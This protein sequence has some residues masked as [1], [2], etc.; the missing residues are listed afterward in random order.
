M[1]TATPSPPFDIEIDVL[2]VGAGGCGLVAALAAHSDGAEV[3]IVEKLDR[4]GGNTM[5]SSGSIPGAG[6]RL[7]QVAGI[8]DDPVRFAA[9]LRRVAGPHD[10]D[11]LVDRL[12]DV[13]AD[14]VHFLIDVAGVNLTLITHY[15]HVGHSVNRLHAPPSRRGADL[16]LDLERAINI[17]DIP[18]ALASPV[19]SLIV[20]DDAVIGAITKM[21]TGETIR[22]GAAATVLACNGFGNNSA[23]LARYCPNMVA[24]PYFGA[25]GSEGEAVSWG[26]ALGA[27]LGNMS[28][29]QAHAGIAQP[30]GSL[31]TWTVIEKG[32]I[33]ID[34]EGKRIA[35]ESI[36]Y[37][38]FAERSAGHGRPT[39]ALYDTR[40]R[41]LTANGQPD[42]A[43]LVTHGGAREA[44]TI[45]EAARLCGCPTSMLANTLQTAASAARGEIADPFGRTFSGLTP[46]VPPFVVT[47]IAPALF[48]TQGGLMVDGD[49]RVLRADATP[50][51]GLY[52]GG[53]AACGI[54]GRRG[55]LG[56]VSGNGL[57]SA[58][59]LGL[60]AGRA[61]AGHAESFKER[62]G[63]SR[64]TRRTESIQT[65]TSS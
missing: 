58:L 62:L 27:Q 24:I 21:A 56:Y 43:E 20:Q 49:A 18:V 37:S 19:T 63:P 53:G 23:L 22:I 38:A 25:L 1:I 42:Y 12:T 10:A 39:F 26:E 29:F 4:F 55:S 28:A 48:H 34:D 52:A 45:E 47:R 32:G 13:S 60:I 46:L 30:H 6:T 17:R 64:D 16:M 11:R 5:L 31:V 65:I 9:D 59:G 57:L 8:D 14:L 51:R 3:A 40:I 50:V 15:R 44:T 54:S 41:D 2:V 35:D 33:I 36:G 7:Q 61:A